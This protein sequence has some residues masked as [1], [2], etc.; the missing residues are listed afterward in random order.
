MI[1]VE[2]R[3]KV[4]DIAKVNEKL[5]P[6]NVSFLRE[7]EQKDFIFGHPVF[8]DSNNMILEGGLSARI[9]KIK[10]EVSLEFKEIIR[11]GGGREFSYKISTI[12]EGRFLLNKLGFKEAF[13][14]SKKRKVYSYDNLLICLD[15]VEGLG[16]FIEIEKLICCESEKNSGRE[17]CISL[18]RKIDNTLIIEDKKYGDL[19]QESINGQSK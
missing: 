8:L 16:D 14:I 11:K 18:L 5:K 4:N 9:R 1:E 3:A 17:E 2:I 6:L 10:E 15:N 12:E 13:S 19:I 7:E